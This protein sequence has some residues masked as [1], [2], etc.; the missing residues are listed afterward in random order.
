MSF[1]PIVQRELR[2]AAR[3]PMMFRIRWWAALLGLG[4]ATFALL[5]VSVSRGRSMGNPLF[6]LLTGY[7]FAM[8]LLAGVFLTSDALTEEKRS[9]TLGLLFLTNLKGYDVVLGKFMAQSLTA[10]YCLLALLPVTALPLLLGGVE[11]AEF[12]RMALALGNAL[13]FSLAAGICVSAFMRDSQRAMGNTL[14]VVLLTAAFLPAMVRAA[15]GVT[16]IPPVWLKLGWLSPFFPFSY[17][18]EALYARNAGAYWASLAGSQLL[19][20]SFLAAASLALPLQL[21]ERGASR[22]RGATAALREDPARRARV[23][24]RNPVEWLLRGNRTRVSW[25]AWFIA[26]G[27]LVTAL[28]V[29]LLAG[30]EFLFVLVY[31]GIPFAFLLKLLFA[32]QA[33]RFFVEARTSGGLE[34]LLCTPLSDQQVIGGQMR[35]LWL[36]FAGPLA[37]FVAGLFLPTLLKIAIV[38]F[39]RSEYES[40]IASAGGFMMGGGELVRLAA[41]LFAVL[42]FGAGLALTSKKPRLAPALTI[43]L[44]LV[45]PAL[46][47]FCWMDVLIDLIFISWGTAKCRQNLRRLISEQYQI[48]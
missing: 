24:D 26:V 15:S 22:A 43:L 1:L 7:G 30:N 20:W 31:C 12:W 47:R 46:F 11:G 27:W 32:M 42:W 3:K 28:L 16:R 6:S 19:A 36:A 38:L 34:L 18:S 21:R 4:L 29:A 25:V 35:A 48:A 2:I 8:A 23:L 41:D 40:L 45:L 44:V 10:F 9:G 5:L 13:F 33:C 37:A 17:S 39:K 14:G